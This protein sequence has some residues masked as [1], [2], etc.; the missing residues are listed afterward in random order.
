[1]SE[2][3]EK[4][5]QKKGALET[6]TVHVADWAGSDKGIVIGLLSLVGWLVAGAL[7]R[8]AEPWPYAFTVYISVITFLVVF[9]QRRAEKKQT[10]AMEAKLDELVAANSSADNSRIGAEK[11]AHGNISADR[12]ADSQ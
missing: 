7:F 4:S 2:P 1:M 12:D 6:A 5:K 11:D 8:F 9:L 3:S 10:I